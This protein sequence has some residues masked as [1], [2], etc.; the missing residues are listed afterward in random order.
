MLTWSF[1][2]LLWI[3]FLFGAW[4]CRSRKNMSLDNW[5][6]RRKNAQQQKS[7]LEAQKSHPDL[8]P[9]ATMK[10]S[11]N[12]AYSVLQGLKSS[13]LQNISW[14][15]SQIQQSWNTCIMYIATSRL[16]VK[17]YYHELAIIIN[18]LVSIWTLWSVKASTIMALTLHTQTNAVMDFK[19]KNYITR[20]IPSFMFHMLADLFQPKWRESFW[21]KASCSLA[22][23]QYQ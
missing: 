3:G 23:Q 16:L 1:P 13:W 19:T 9:Q 20:K 18:Y 5:V 12:N 4:M 22:E 14:D 11:N 15:R 7:T 2:V 21:K 17:K 8:H 10:Q 6:W